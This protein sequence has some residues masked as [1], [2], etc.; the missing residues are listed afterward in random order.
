MEPNKE[1]VH[2]VYQHIRQ[3]PEEF[4]MSRW[5]SKTDCGTIACFAATSAFVRG[6][7]FW[8]PLD[9]FYNS[10]TGPDAPSFNEHLEAEAMKV[11]R[12]MFFLSRWPSKMRLEYFDSN[13]PAG[14]IEVLRKAIIHYTGYDPE[15]EPNA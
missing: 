7:A 8:D 14:R 2:K 10:Y 15:E 13:S 4:D 3:N 12:D 6:V 5:A 1:L 11:P 9:N